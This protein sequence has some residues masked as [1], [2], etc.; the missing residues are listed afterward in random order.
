[1]S[2]AALDAL[3]AAR[4]RSDPDRTAFIEGDRTLTFAALDAHAN[5]LTRALIADGVGPGDRVGYLGRNSMTFVELMFGVVRCGAVIVPLNWRLATRE[6]AY[7]LADCRSTLVVVEPEFAEAARLAADP[8]R[9]RLGAGHAYDTWR[10]AHDSSPVTSRSTAGAPCLQI[11]SSGTTGDPKGVVL[12]SHAMLTKL[13][14][15]RPSWRLDERSVCLLSGPVHHVAGV[16]VALAGV[17]AGAVQVIAREGN[18]AAVV[19]LIGRHQVTFAGT[20]PAVLAA[21]AALPAPE[22]AQMRSLDLVMYGS[23]PLPVALLRRCQQVLGCDFVQAYGMTETAGSLTTLSPQDHRDRAHAHRLASVG[24]PHANIDL[25]LVDPE[26]GLD[27]GTGE[28]GEIWVRSEQNMLEYFGQ[29]EA[30][31]QALTGDGWLRTGDL[32]GLDA[33]GY[34]YLR[35]RLKH[36]IIFGGENVYSVEVERAV[37]EYPGVVDCAVV[38]RPSARWGESPVAFVVS[39]ADV[40]PDAVIAFCRE[41]LAHFKC[42]TQV[43]RVEELPRTAAGKIDKRALRFPGLV[44]TAPVI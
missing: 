2:L 40:R 27:V 18:P 21:L 34:L 10:Q 16:T 19:E 39:S 38:G 28:T 1:V 3:A 43:I 9:T 17:A 36:L 6:L 23:A 37:S 32:G 7:V 4:A 26:T 12:T 8:D 41:R 35:D 14:Q 13:A 31:A 42:P 30:T 11:Y 29:P 44:T 24:R 5:Q 25:R 22:L 15:V 20:V 33:D